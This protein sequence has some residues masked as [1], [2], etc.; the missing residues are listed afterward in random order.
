KKEAERKAKESERK[1]KEA[2]Q[3]ELAAITAAIKAVR[4]TAT[5]SISRAR[6]NANIAL[7]NY[8]LKANSAVKKT[9]DD[10]EAKIISLNKLGSDYPSKL[11][12]FVEELTKDSK[13]D[14]T[15]KID[16]I[17]EYAKQTID[18]V[19]TNIKSADEL[20]DTLNEK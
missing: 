10:T 20:L 13:D 4:D 14:I 18:T 6:E 16:K 11:T 12:K 8:E 9:S 2:A 19:K 1:A 7:K 17:S 3:T 5:T 15:I